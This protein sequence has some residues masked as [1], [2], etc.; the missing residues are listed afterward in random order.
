MVTRK[1]WV[2]KIGSSRRSKHL[3]S[4]ARLQAGSRPGR[5]VVAW[6]P[7]EVKQAVAAHSLH[8]TNI[9]LA[10]PG[11]RAVFLTHSHILF[12]VRCRVTRHHVYTNGLGSR[13]LTIGPQNRVWCLNACSDTLLLVVIVGMGGNATA[14]GYEQQKQVEYSPS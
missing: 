6:C 5:R 2:M 11:K 8:Q 12:V 7:Y 4:L 1:C 3:Q 9:T 13:C 10:R 14:S